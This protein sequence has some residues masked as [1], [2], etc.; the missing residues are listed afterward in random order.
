LI[1]IDNF[2]DCVIYLFCSYA[3]NSVFIVAQLGQLS[4]THFR[5]F[6]LPSL[7]AERTKVEE[8]LTSHQ[9]HYGSYRGRVLRVKWPNQQC[10]GSN[11]DI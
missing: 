4:S 7:P 8:G 3:N 10:E 6:S 9:R 1:S 11:E 5:C 2:F